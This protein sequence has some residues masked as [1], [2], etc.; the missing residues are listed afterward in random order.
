[1]HLPQRGAEGKHFV[2]VGRVDIGLPRHTDEAGVACTLNTG[3]SGHQQLCPV[4]AECMRRHACAGPGWQ[5]CCF[6]LGLSTA[7]LARRTALTQRGCPALT[8]RLS[9][10]VSCSNRQPAPAAGALGATQAAWA[11]LHGWVSGRGWAQGRESA[12][13]RNICLSRLMAWPACSSNG[14]LI[15]AGCTT[16]LL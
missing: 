6:R 3:C 9:R 11:T 15:I 13:A 7:K 2:H 14:L 4:T 16:A 10:L 8:S 1:M 5:W 12:H